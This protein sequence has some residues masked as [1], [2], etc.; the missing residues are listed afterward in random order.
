VTRASRSIWFF[1][2]RRR[3]RT[4]SPDYGYWKSLDFLGFSRPNR[5]LSMGYEGFSGN[6]ISR[7]FLFDTTVATTGAHRL[8]LQE[9]MGVHGASID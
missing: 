4:K 8:R 9:G 3:F 5:D 6:N 2:A 1:L 7:R